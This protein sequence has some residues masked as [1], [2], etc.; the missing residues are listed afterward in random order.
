[1][2]ER[3]P[4]TA[5]PAVPVLP[6]P[7]VPADDTEVAEPLADDVEPAVTPE[8]RVDE[9]GCVVLRGGV[10]AVPRVPE[11]VR[12]RVPAVPVEPRG[13]TTQAPAVPTCVPPPCTT[14]VPLICSCG[15]WLNWPRVEVFAVVVALGG[16]NLPVLVGEA[17]AWQN[18]YQNAGVASAYAVL[19]LGISL[20]VTLFYLLV[21]RV[22]EETLA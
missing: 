14:E 5:T 4:G 15:G 22:R 17:Y 12:P 6:G 16:R 3:W 18:D 19:V 11:P 8:V 1:M 13:P 7:P 20:A 10:A 9:P 2:P 21:L